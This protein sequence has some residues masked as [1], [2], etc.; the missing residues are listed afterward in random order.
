MSPRINT[1][2]QVHGSDRTALFGGYARYADRLPLDYLAYGD[3]T[4]PAGEAYRWNDLNGDR[5]LQPGEQGVLV[6]SVGPCCA[7]AIPNSIDPHLCA[8]R[9]DEF[10]VG[11]EH[12]IAGNL[13]L[14]LVGTDRRD[15]PLVAPV[16][17]GVGLADYTA[18]IPTGSRGRLDWAGR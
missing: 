11:V 7:R 1:R 16:N 6:A 13:R 9:S 10:V 3:R 18:Q 14:R 15:R 12:R 17:M 8:P 2:W 5:L 4:G